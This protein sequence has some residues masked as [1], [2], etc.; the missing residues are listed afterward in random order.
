MEFRLLGPVE[1][2]SS[3]QEI[4][5][6]GTKVRML[7]AVLLLEAGRTVPF[8]T[9]VRRVWGDEAPA[10][11][12]TSVQAY[13]SRL[14][15]RLEQADN[16][17]VRLEHMPSIG[18]RLVV[19]AEDVDALEFTRIVIEGQAAAAHGER[20]RAIRL[21]QTASAMVRGEPLSGMP[22]DWAHS[23][24]I[25]LQDRLRTATVTRIGLQLER[26]D[27]QSLIT[28]L[29]DLHGD[30]PLDEAVVRL[31]M[32]AL[33]AAGRRADALTTFQTMHRRMREELGIEPG[34]A[35]RDL[36]QQSLHGE[37][38]VP[39][40]AQGPPPT[41]DAPPIPDTLERDPPGFVGRQRHLDVLR[42]EISEALRSGQSAVC[43]IDGMPGVGKTTIALRLA[44]ELRSRCPDGALQVPL[45]SHDRH[46][47]PTT[48]EAALRLLLGMLQVDVRELRRATDL[49]QALVLWRRHT[50]GRRL[51]LLFD[52]VGDA[53]QIRALLPSGPGNVVLVTCRRQLADLPGAI[54]H[55]LPL[56]RSEDARALFTSTAEV[57]EDGD[58]AALGAIIRTCGR[59][60]LAL[61]IAGAQLRTRRS[62]TVSDFAE[63]LARSLAAQGMDGL[64][65]R[66]NATFET[67]YRD[68]PALPRRVLR[69]LALHPGARI[70]PFFIAALAGIEL[71][72]AEV[73]LDTLVG[74]HLLAE[75]QSHRYQL[76]DLVK[77]F[78]RYR[79]G[80]DEQAA[81]IRLARERL[82]S[83]V[84]DA[85]DRAT[86]CFHPY[87]HL[88]LSPIA[89]VQP[90]PPQFT[91]AQQAGEWLDREQESVR[92]LILDAYGDGRDRE[93]AAL[94][95]LLAT[96][97]DRRSLWHESVVL[98]YEKALRTWAQLENAPGQAYALGDLATAFWRLGKLDQALYCS[99]TALRIWERLGDVDGTADTLLRLGRIQYSRHHLDDATACY[100]Q[101]AALSA[102]R[103]DE[104]GEAQALY[105]L[106]VVLFDAGH[107]DEG[108]ADTKRA[109]KLA[110]EA[111]DEAIERNILNNLGEFRRTCGEYDEAL[112]CYQQSMVL[113]ERIGDPRNVALAASNL[114]EI[115]ELLGRP[116]EALVHLDRALEMFKRLGTQTNATYTLLAK[117]RACLLLDDCAQ[118]AELLAQATAASEQ[119]PDPLLAAHVHLTG[120]A[121]YE[122]QHDCGAALA[123]YRSALARAR[124]AHAIPERA[125]AHRGVG[126]VLAASGRLA[127]ARSSWRRALELFAPFDAREAEAL[128]LRLAEADTA[129]DGPGDPDE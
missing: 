114:G 38:V 51:L 120:G 74:H 96:Y 53:E 67:S 40:R 46:Q 82:L 104:Q 32:R 56:M 101:S 90:T 121:L 1:L 58:T 3:G 21:L 16:D 111:H 14:R 52:D 30:Y 41:P 12:A 89:A 72:D 70:S 85:V 22:G 29:R 65:E 27:P 5:L 71:F 66:L 13:L 80:L 37:D 15:R 19:A 99:Q 92:L 84:L 69:H 125:K 116:R 78:A 8:D 110:R 57:A 31:L 33:Y 44:H 34:R 4:D 68:L 10:K 95:H 75:P 93:A 59:L 112:E 20:E 115:H 25:G 126:N 119:S 91:T 64:S 108:I 39:R 26:D 11:V 7:L 47:P 81:D 118:A 129:G 55:T 109:L 28:E 23:A 86:A 127:L 105:L 97:L 48:A 35:L 88:N 36:Q 102:S 83:F 62:W 107:Y 94:T 113:A 100:R 98:L 9:L 73:A 54:R 42:E 17:S 60:P 77:S 128:R 76:H 2:W 49:D 123:E 6:G 45:R 103:G 63:R 61:S 43:I 18:Y 87:R 79:L 117:A 124:R 24:R 122:R 106:G 50:Q